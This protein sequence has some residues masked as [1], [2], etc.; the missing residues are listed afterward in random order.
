MSPR[1]WDRWSKA[2]PRDLARY[3]AQEAVK[4]CQ[5]IKG[6]DDLVHQADGR[7][8]LIQAL[9]EALTKLEISYAPEEI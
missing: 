1:R 9:Y 8:L 3:V 7:R 5:L 2:M 6:N 4:V